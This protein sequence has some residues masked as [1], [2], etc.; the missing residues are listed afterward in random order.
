[1]YG[2]KPPTNLSNYFI[3]KNVYLQIEEMFETDVSKSSKNFTYEDAF[4]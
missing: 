1:M 2:T 4:Y 3:T